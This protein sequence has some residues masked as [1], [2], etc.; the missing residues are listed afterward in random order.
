M[1]WPVLL[2]AALPLLPACTTAGGQMASDLPARAPQGEC[3]AAGVQHFVGERATGEIGGILLQRTGADVL[4]WV[5]P[6]SAVTMDFRPDRL[7]VSYDG[8][9]IIERISCG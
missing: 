5:P 6:H 3:N 7:T 9:Y 4:R 8:N 1:R 2:L